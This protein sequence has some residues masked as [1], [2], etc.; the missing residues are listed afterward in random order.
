MFNVTTRKLLLLCSLGRAIFCMEEPLP[1]SAQEISKIEGN[2]D[3]M[4]DSS[5]VM[6]KRFLYWLEDKFYNEKDDHRRLYKELFGGFILLANAQLDI[7]DKV[8]QIGWRLLEVN[9]NT[10]N[11]NMNCSIYYAKHTRFCERK[12]S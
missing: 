3:T 10:N 8:T 2:R 7:I 9:N 6:A 11:N 1:V 12:L 4:D 5:D